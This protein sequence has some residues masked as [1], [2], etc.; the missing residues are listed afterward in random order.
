MRLLS[1][2]AIAALALAACNTPKTPQPA[3]A[4]G[5]TASNKPALICTSR[6]VT[7]S[8][9]PVHECHTAQEWADIKSRGID[10]FSLEA[11]RHAPS[12]GGN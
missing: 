11:Q 10:D 4:P 7:G 3:A 2:L 5:A 8:R 12:T 9:M 6:E 1:T